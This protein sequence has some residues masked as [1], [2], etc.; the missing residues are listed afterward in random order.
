MFYTIFIYEPLLVQTKIEGL[1]KKQCPRAPPGLANKI[2]AKGVLK[3]FTDKPQAK[4]VLKGFSNMNQAK[5]VLKGFS[6]RVK[7]KESSKIP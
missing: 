5:S 1:H 3:G 6:N 2:Q 7:P 4:G